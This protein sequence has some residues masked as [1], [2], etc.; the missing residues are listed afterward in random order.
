MKLKFCKYQGTGNDFIMIDDRDERFEV[1]N[2]D[3]VKMLCDRKFGIGADGLIL[4]Q[5]HK[6][7]DFRMIYFNSDGKESSMCGNGGR[8]LVMFAQYLGIIGEKCTFK[9]VD[10]VHEAFIRDEIVHLRMNDVPVVEEKDKTYFLNTGSPHY[11]EWVKNIN[12]Y[13]V[14]NK[15][16]SIRYSDRFA[17]DGTNVNFL[18]AVGK[19]EIFVRTYERGVENE[20]LSCGTGVTAASLVASLSEGFDSPIVIH[21]L[22]GDLKVSYSKVINSFTNI[23]LIGP[24]QMIFKGKYYA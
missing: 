9:A 3:L 7:Y 24:A 13:D 19:N 16:K 4:L 20:T 11:V 14:F 5:E 18:E 12:N 22:G 1:G 10:G 17:P 2:K 21:T 6:K 8:C 23:Y 15:G